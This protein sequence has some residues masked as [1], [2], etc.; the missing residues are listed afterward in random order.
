MDEKIYY[1]INDNLYQKVKNSLLGIAV[2]K[3]YN[4]TTTILKSE[5]EL[6]FYELITLNEVIINRPELL[7]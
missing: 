1:I 7:I 5:Q 4:D 2:L 3:K 6:L